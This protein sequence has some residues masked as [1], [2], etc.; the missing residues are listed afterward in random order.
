MLIRTIQITGFIL[1]TSCGSHDIHH[2]LVKA[3]EVP[4]THSDHAVLGQA[5]HLHKKRFLNVAC[6]EGIV[7]ETLGN[8]QASIELAESNLAIQSNL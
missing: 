7:D 4:S 8:S 5:Y 1:I 3:S 6:V 2:N